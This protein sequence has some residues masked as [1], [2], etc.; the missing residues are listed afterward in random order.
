[1]VRRFRGEPRKFVTQLAPPSGV[2]AEIGVWKGEFSAQIL[3][4]ARP[5]KLHL[6]DPWR[7]MTAPEYAHARYGSPS[8]A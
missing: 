5:S 7:F 4:V 1:M 6:I 2:C 3:K 8:P